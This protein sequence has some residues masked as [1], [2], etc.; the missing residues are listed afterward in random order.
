MQSDETLSD[1][2]IEAA[3]DNV[4]KEYKEGKFLHSQ[5]VCSNGD[6]AHKAFR[7]FRKKLLTDTLPQDIIID[8][9]EDK[10]VEIKNDPKYEVLRKTGIDEVFT[11]AVAAATY[12]NTERLKVAP[13]TISEFFSGE[14]KGMSGFS[15]EFLTE[16]VKRIPETRVLVVYDDFV[17]TIEYAEKNGFKGGALPFRISRNLGDTGIAHEK[18]SMI[19]FTRPN[20]QTKSAL[21]AN[22]QTPGGF[23]NDVAQ[24]QVQKLQS[25]IK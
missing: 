7:S 17:N 25:F 11:L 16:R 23:Y 14:G 15:H 19:G 9:S 18:F 2:S 24:L 1:E 4:I 13:E 8:C 22:S 12:D 5:I 20:D 10:L 21:K 3:T 6:D